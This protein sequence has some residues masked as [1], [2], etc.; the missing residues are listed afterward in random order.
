MLLSYDGTLSEV[1][2]KMKRFYIPR[3]LIAVAFFI[4]LAVACSKGS[5]SPVAPTD[6]TNN[7]DSL[8][9]KIS[10]GMPIETGDEIAYPVQFGEA[11]DLYA[12]SFRVGFE[13]SGLEPIGVEWS[14]E[15]GE[16]DATF[17][18]CD[19]RDFVPLAFARYSGMPGLQGHG[20]IAFVRFRI[21]SRDHRHPWI[22]NDVRFLKARDSVGNN[23]RLESGGDSR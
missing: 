21:I 3:Y 18:V 23:L 5:N 9:G 10:L 22:I 2:L 12:M 15:V 13:P 16:E 4:V 20:T 8:G 7:G 14:D 11:A 1:L 19:Q 17:H 6:D